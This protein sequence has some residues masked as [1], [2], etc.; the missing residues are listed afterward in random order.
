MLKETETEEAIDF[1]CHIFVMGGISIAGRVSPPATPNR[2]G[3]LLSKNGAMD[4][5]AY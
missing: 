3:D 4:G 2:G 5:Y 1:F